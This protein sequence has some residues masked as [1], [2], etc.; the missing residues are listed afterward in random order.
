MSVRRFEDRPEFKRGRVG[1][2]LIACW[3]RSRGFTIS[4]VYE[5]EI[6]EG[7]G[8]RL[9]TPGRNLIAPDMLAF[10]PREQHVIRWIEAK[11]KTVF[12]WY[13]KTG[14]WETG[15][16]LKHYLDYCQ[17]ADSFSYPIWLLFLH[18]DTH[19]PMPGPYP[20]PTGLFGNDL[21]FLRRNESHRWHNPPMVYWGI[22]T[23]FKIATLEQV[24]D[25]SKAA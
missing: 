17:I 8:P 12:S 20:C 11:Q 7:K 24:R 5:K 14:S 22:E 4:P 9:F 10:K 3:L 1:E 16:D 2:S 21:R 13:R 25:A 6:D 23:L 18:T 19:G 15:I